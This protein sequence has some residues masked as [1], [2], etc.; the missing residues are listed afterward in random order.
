MESPQGG[1]TDE[2]GK[3]QLRTCKEEPDPRCWKIMEVVDKFW[4]G[5]RPK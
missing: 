2:G 3:R 5:L 4:R 1:A